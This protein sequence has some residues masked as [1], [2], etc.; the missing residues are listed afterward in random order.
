MYLQ[1]STQTHS[2]HPLTTSISA[3]PGFVN[4][5]LGLCDYCVMFLHTMKK[6]KKKKKVNKVESDSIL[7]MER[8]KKK[9]LCWR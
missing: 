1:L 2:Y 6:E 3:K 7:Q 5:E 9:D 8:I 4:F